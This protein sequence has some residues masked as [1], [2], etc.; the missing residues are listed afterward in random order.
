MKLVAK[1]Q[2]LVEA[3]QVNYQDRVAVNHM[4]NS[5]KQ[6]IEKARIDPH[7]RANLLQRLTGICLM[8]KD[9]CGFKKLLKSKKIDAKTIFDTSLD[10]LNGNHRNGKS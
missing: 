1:I 10:A 6:R 9:D 5:L 7:S 8:S 4:A 3:A 2:L